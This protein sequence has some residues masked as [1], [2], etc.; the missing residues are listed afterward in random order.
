MTGSTGELGRFLGG[1]SREQSDIK[2]NLSADEVEASNFL[3]FFEQF[4][5][6]G[7]LV[8]TK[9]FYSDDALVWNHPVYGDLNVYSWNDTH[10]TSLDVVVLDISF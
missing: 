6:G 10:D 8:V 5:V 1:L 3:F 2:S 4:I 9:K 7:E